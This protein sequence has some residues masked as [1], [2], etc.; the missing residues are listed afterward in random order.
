MK[1]ILIGAIVYDNLFYKNGKVGL[2]RSESLLDRRSIQY[3][4]VV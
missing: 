3:V 1:K 4:K 2:T